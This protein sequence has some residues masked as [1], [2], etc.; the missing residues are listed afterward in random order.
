MVA[1]RA[2]I[3]LSCLPSLASLFTRQHTSTECKEWGQQ[4]ATMEIHEKKC[5]PQGDFPSKPL[6]H[7][8]CSSVS[9]QAGLSSEA[10]NQPLDALGSH[11]MGEGG[12][13]RHHRATSIVD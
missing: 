8:I 13:V 3:T 1:H 7:C 12:A 2:Y 11:V 10:G 4:N 5:N 9:K 6:P